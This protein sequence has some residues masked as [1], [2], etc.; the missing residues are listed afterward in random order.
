MLQELKVA[1]MLADAELTC[2]LLLLLLRKVELRWN[3]G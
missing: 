1:T 2:V 3:E